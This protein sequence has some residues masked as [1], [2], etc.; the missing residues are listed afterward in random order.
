MD[1][2]YSIERTDA[3]F[4]HRQHVLPDFDIT[5]QAIAGVGNTDKSLTKSIVAKT[6]ATPD[7]LPRPSQRTSIAMLVPLS[8]NSNIP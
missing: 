4:L 5:M 3:D 2:E 7:Y 8:I 1:V 6:V